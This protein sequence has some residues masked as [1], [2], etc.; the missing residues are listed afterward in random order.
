MLG[1]AVR[2]KDSDKI[3]GFFTAN[4]EFELITK[5]QNHNVVIYESPFVIGNH[6]NFSLKKFIRECK[7]I[8][9]V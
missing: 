1:I 5:M 9:L 6:G 8:G 3:K 2:E 4:S 7:K